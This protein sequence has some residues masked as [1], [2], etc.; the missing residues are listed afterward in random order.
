MSAENPLFSARRRYEGVRLVT[1]AT[2]PPGS[3]SDG[4]DADKLLLAFGRD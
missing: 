4:A 2:H 1:A 3:S